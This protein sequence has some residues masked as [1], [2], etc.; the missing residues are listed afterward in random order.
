MQPCAHRPHSRSPA[1]SV[2]KAR[3]HVH[4]FRHLY[5]VQLMSV[6]FW[7]R[8]AKSRKVSP[9]PNT[10]ALYDTRDDQSDDEFF[11]RTAAK[12][13]HQVSAF[14]DSGLSVRRVHTALS[15]RLCAAPQHHLFL[16]AVQK[17]STQKVEEAEPADGSW[18]RLALIHRLLLV[19]S[20]HSR[21]DAD[22]QHSSTAC[23][24]EK[25]VRTPNPQDKKPPGFRP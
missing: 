21:D 18:R 1:C 15:S 8:D 5:I 16:Q 11:D 2:A 4:G 14:G 20:T 7:R 9:Q 19:C 3:F 24:L 6:S 12:L 25:P 23:L 22:A 17:A 13:G 10:Q